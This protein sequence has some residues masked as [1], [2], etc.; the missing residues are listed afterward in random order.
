MREIV[1]VTVQPEERSRQLQ[2]E[3]GSKSV[4]PVAIER[5]EEGAEVLLFYP[6]DLD[7]E[8]LVKPVF[9]RAVVRAAISGPCAPPSRPRLISG[10]A[11][12]TFETL[13]S[14]VYAP[15]EELFSGLCEA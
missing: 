11:L 9:D 15:L 6:T 13:C 1:E 4:Y 14:A 8:R 7:F 3:F 2:Q 10:T 5:K 12:A